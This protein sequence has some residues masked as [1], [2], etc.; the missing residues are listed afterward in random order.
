MKRF[1]LTLDFPNKRIFL[2][3]NKFFNDRFEFNMAGLIAT[4]TPEGIVRISQIIE[5]SEG[6]KAGLKVGDLILKI[7][8]RESANI[9]STELTKLFQNENQILE[10]VIKSGEITKTISVKLRRII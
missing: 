10:L 2:K 7:N 6:E 1:D 3:P 4:R 9:E 8:N 5:N